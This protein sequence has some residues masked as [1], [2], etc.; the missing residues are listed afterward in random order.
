MNLLDVNI[1]V[2][3][4]RQDSPRH[5]EYRAWLLNLINGPEKYGLAE[6]ALMGMIRI[7]T[8]N[9]IFKH[10]SSLAEVIAFTNALKQPLNCCIVRPSPNH[11]STFIKAC[12]QVNAKGNLITDAWFAALVST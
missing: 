7:T 2:Y 4:F 3:A 11:W 10:P 12:Q 5:Q 8:N 6:L 1:L 9:K